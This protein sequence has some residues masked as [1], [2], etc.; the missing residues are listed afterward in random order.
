MLIPRGVR[1]KGARGVNATHKLREKF[2]FLQ[3]REAQN[4]VRTP[5]SNFKL[6]SS[7]LMNCLFYILKRKID[8]TLGIYILFSKIIIYMCTKYCSD[9]FGRLLKTKIFFFQ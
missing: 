9:D 5:L 4:K 6:S 2:I 3:T 7:I 8:I 1:G